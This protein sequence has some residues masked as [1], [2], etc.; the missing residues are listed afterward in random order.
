M[1]NNR[2]PASRSRL[3][4]SRPPGFQVVASKLD[5][6]QLPEGQPL[7]HAGREFTCADLTR[8]LSLNHPSHHKEYSGTRNILTKL[9][10]QDS[11]M[12]ITRRSET[13][14]AAC[15]SSSRQVGRRRTI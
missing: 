1:C 4:S 2:Q 14:R 6:V 3:T 10:P 12:T 5:D 8:F 13:C 11:V 7:N 15:R 9:L